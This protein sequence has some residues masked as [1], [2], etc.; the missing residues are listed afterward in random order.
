[1]LISISPSHAQWHVVDAHHIQVQ[2]HIFSVAPRVLHKCSTR[3]PSKNIAPEWCMHS[4]QNTAQAIT[5]A[6]ELA[7]LDAWPDVI[8][9]KRRFFNDPLYEGQWYLPYIE[10]DILLDRDMGNPN[11]TVAVIDSGIDISHPDFAGKIIA[12]KDTAD[13]D[14]D[15]SPNPGDYCFSQSNDICDDHG[16]AVSGIAVASANNG[17]GMVGLCPN[18]SLMPIR[19]LGSNTL[20]SDILAFSHA[21]ENG[22]DVINNSWGYDESMPTPPPLKDV[23]QKVFQEGR[24]GK[25]SIIIFAAGNDDREVQPGELCALEEVLCVSAIDSYGRPTAYT[26]YGSAIDIAAPSATV[27]IAPQ[28]QT[29]INFGGTSAAAPV[30]TGISGWILSQDP[31]ISAQEVYNLLRETAQPSPLVTHDEYGHHSFYGYGVISPQNL[32]N[33]MYPEE[34][35]APQGCTYVPIFPYLFSPFLLFLYRRR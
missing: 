14:D 1:M 33:T 15:P 23:I 4:V 13:N 18:C 6:Q 22:A 28:E 10:A 3:I 11:I 24:E 35:D 19:M 25:G 20:S 21:L 7:H 16:T 9:P 12:P 29:T 17:S 2:D 32:L 8:L 26:N 5:R 34:E 30:V 27:S 31:S